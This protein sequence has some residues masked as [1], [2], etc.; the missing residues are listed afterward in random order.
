MRRHPGAAVAVAAASAAALADV[1]GTI[2]LVC[3]FDGTLA[4]IEPDPEGAALH[5]QARRALRHLGRIARARPDRLALAIL[6]GRTALDVAGRVR[7]G[8]V[9]YLGDHWVI[10]A[11]AGM[12]YAYI[13]YY[14]VVHAPARLRAWRPAPLGP[15]PPAP[16][17]SG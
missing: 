5:P 16:S 10:D 15:R 17:P 3:D 1:D 13:A 9:T 8:G 4:A 12:A 6:S 14:A 2:L 7:I 11:L